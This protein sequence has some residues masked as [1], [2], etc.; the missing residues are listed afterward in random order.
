MAG[1][2]RAHNREADAVN[3][4][5]AHEA[6][7]SRHRASREAQPLCLLRSSS[8]RSLDLIE[9]SL[10]LTSVQTSSSLRTTLVGMSG[11]GWFAALALR[12]LR[13]QSI[14]SAVTVGLRS[15]AVSRIF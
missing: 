12:S 7:R 14:S 1:L 9:R 6:P 8:S 4:F 5:G 2:L 15:I 3:E 13:N 10:G 11:E